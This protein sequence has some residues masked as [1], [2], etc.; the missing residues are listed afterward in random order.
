MKQI[1]IYLLILL[2]I[3]SCNA[4]SSNAPKT[5]TDTLQCDTSETEDTSETKFIPPKPIQTLST[6]P[7]SLSQLK[8]TKWKELSPADDDE[9]STWEFTDSRIRQKSYCKKDNYQFDFTSPFYISNT[10][11]TK[12]DKTLVGK[13]SKGDYLVTCIGRNL[14]RLDWYTIM[15]C[16]LKTGD[17]YLFRER[18]E[19]EIGGRDVTIHLKLIK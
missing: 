12:F 1:V 18:E 13:N 5:K 10:K 6:A 8:G 4:P 11:P 9:E 16:D 15:A 14:E 17:M 7:V 3:S 2:G 19:D